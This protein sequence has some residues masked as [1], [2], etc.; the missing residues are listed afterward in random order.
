MLWKEAR[1]LYAKYD[2]C[3]AGQGT[4]VAFQ[5]KCK[6]EAY[7]CGGCK[8]LSKHGCKVQSLSCALHCCYVGNTH[9][10]FPTNALTVSIQNRIA[11]LRRIA[12]KHNIPFNGR[13][14]KK[15]NFK[16]HKGY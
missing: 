2:L 16:T 4:C 14:C 5:L 3:K 6:S 8:H 11:T 10:Y 1:R 9:F 15:D 12:L 7:C 13:S